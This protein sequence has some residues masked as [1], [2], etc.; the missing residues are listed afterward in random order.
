MF[1]A[2]FGKGLWSAF[3]LS[4]GADIQA[5]NSSGFVSTTD[6]AFGWIATT[7]SDGSQVRKP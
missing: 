3:A 2:P 4:H 7:G 1:S 6:M 5:S